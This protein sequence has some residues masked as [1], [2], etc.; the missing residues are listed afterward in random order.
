MINFQSVTESV[1]RRVIKATE[2]DPLTQLQRENEV[3]D[4]KGKDLWLREYT[5]GGEEFL[6]SSRRCR[7]N[8][9]VV[10]Y[11][12]NTPIGQGLEKVNAIVEAIKKE[13]DIV[14]S[15][16]TA[17]RSIDYCVNVKSIKVTKSNNGEVSST[18]V[19]LVLDVISS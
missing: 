5:T 16:R 4:P 19:A 1:R 3:F 9:F 15:R 7:A 13:F 17:I 2:I 11:E 12:I 6:T 10:Q 14:N 18:A 8:A